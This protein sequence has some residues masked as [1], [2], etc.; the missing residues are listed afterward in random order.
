M[1][2][3][4]LVNKATRV[5]YRVGFK[6]RKH[7]PEIL[8]VGGAVG[9]VASGVMACRATTKL[10]EILEEPKQ[11]IEKLKKY[12][13]EK[14][15]T[16]K[17]SEEDS[18]KDLAI[19]YVQSGVKVAKLYAPSVTLGALSLGCMLG[20]N[21]ILRKRNIGLAAAYATIDKSF[22]GYRKRVVERFGEELDREL[23]YNIKAKEIEEIKID[24]KGKEK[25]EKTTVSAVDP[26][27][28]SDYARFFDASCTGWEKNAEYN[29]MFLKQ[30]QNHA[31]DLLKKRGHLFLNEVY[32]MLGFD[33]TEAGQYV[34]WLYDEKFPNGDNFVDFGIYDMDKER[35]RAFVNG[36]EPVILLDFNVDGKISHLL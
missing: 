17:Y 11:E 30:Q 33:R 18:K 24:S 15:Y 4:E 28:H 35:N 26:T 2:R 34:G 19:L 3:T 23:R 36:H 21:H 6:L 7:S 27:I 16:E 22:K 29:L 10:S 8:A 14:G 1:N 12:V 13:G 5:F 32:D 31:N 20:S 25:V 9:V